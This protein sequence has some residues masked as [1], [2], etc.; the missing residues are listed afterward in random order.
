MDRVCRATLLLLG[1]LSAC[2]GP[3]GPVGADGAGFESL[4]DPQIR[5]KVIF[6]EPSD[7][8]VGPYDSYNQVQIRFNKIMDLSSLRRAIR[9]TSPL[10]DVSTDTSSVVSTA[11]DLVTICAGG[12]P[13]SQFGFYCR[14]DV[15]YSMSII[16]EAIEANCNNMAVPYSYP[17][18]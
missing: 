12:P 17:H 15:H 2:K 6:T 5:P 16:T 14:I 11:G 13:G 8:T 9:F 4:T 3:S 1:W 18:K 10:N 7:G